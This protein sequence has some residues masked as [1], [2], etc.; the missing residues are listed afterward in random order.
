[1]SLNQQTQNWVDQRTRRRCEQIRALRIA[2]ADD[3]TSFDAIYA[4]LHT[5]H[6]WEDAR[7]DGPPNLLVGSDVLAINTISTFLLKILDGSLNG[8]S[9]SDKLQA[10][11]EILGQLPIVAKACVRPVNE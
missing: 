5:Q 3:T 4:Y 7:D 10:V 11:N 2:L 8:A 6:D 1:M 9:D